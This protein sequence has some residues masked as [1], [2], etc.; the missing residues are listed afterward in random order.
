MEPKRWVALDCFKAAAIF[1]MISWHLS[2]WWANLNPAVGKSL[3]MVGVTPWPYFLQVVVAFSGHFVMS[4][5]VIA[6]ASLRFYLDK[7]GSRLNRKKVMAAIAKRASALAALGFT[8][9]LLAFGPEY[10]HL[11]NVLQL[12]SLSMVIIAFLALYSSPY[13]LA[14]SGFA[15]IF[16]APFMRDFLQGADYYPAFA[17]VGDRLGDNIWSFF[18]WYGVV[19]YGFL[20]AHLYL[21]FKAKKQENIFRVVLASASLLIIFI[22]FIKGSFFYAVDLQYPWGPLLFQPHTLTVL[23]QLSVFTLLIMLA[24]VISSGIKLSKFGIINVFSKGILWIYIAHMVVGFRLIE[25]LVDNGFQS[26]PVLFFVMA[27]IFM[28]SYAVGAALVLKKENSS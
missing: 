12:V 14:I 21:S 24:D 26:G 2:I 16:S 22:A 13:L 1:V 5:P 19:V 7:H 27:F 28:L 8:M 20:A 9:N 17:L 11:W 4:I 3:L 23:A 10:W 25:F 15:V 18:P 6:G